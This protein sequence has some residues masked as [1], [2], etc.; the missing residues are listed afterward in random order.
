MATN[1]W[2]GILKRIGISQLRFQKIWQACDGRGWLIWHSFSGRPR[3]V[4]NCYGN[5]LHLEVV[6]RRRHERPLLFAL[7]FDNRFDDREAAFKGLNN[8]KPAT[9]CTNLVSFR[10]IISEFTLLKRGDSA[11][12]WRST[13]IRHTGV[14][15]GLVYRNWFQNRNRQSFLYILKNLVRFES[16]APEFKT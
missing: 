15:Y 3:D 4:A 13:F 8:N 16:V 11:A 5:R 10:P 9:L 1:F 14:R 6:R 7:A 12:I 2:A